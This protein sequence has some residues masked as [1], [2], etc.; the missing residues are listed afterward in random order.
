VSITIEP[1]RGSHLEDAA[2]LFCVRYRALRHHLPILPARYTTQEVILPML[3]DLAQ[4]APGVVAIDDRQ[5]VGFLLGF[6]IP[7]FLGKRSV[8]SPEW[9]NATR[10]E[11]SRRLY[12]EMYGRLSAEW[13]A[14]HCFT[15]LVSLLENDPQGRDAWHW[16]GFGLAAVD[17]VRDLEPVHSAPTGYALRR[18]TLDDLPLA[19]AFDQALSQHLA[20]A[21]TFW[22]H[23]NKDYGN[24]LMDSANAFWLASPVDQGHHE[25]AVGFIALEPGYQEGCQVIQ[26]EKT[27]SI[28][29]AFTRQ[30]TRGEGVATALLNISLEWARAQGYARCAVDFE[31]MNSLAA[32]FWPKY[33]QPVCYS[34]MRRVD[35]RIGSMVT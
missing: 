15:H 26:D 2:E 8:F 32:R 12:Q 3:R 9:A 21:P 24:W 22:P 14:D 13:V 33:F 7:D 20:A 29:G 19:A 23:E 11:A 30:E 1:L 17:G 5:L 6:V 18:A 10:P 28:S 34:L 4:A 31:P 27:I 25:D 16:L 35:A